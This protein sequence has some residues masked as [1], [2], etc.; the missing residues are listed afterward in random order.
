MMTQQTLAQTTTSTQGEP[1][2]GKRW[3][4]LQQERL[5]PILVVV[6]AAA[7]ASSLVAERVGAPDSLILL[8][9]IVSYVAGGWFGLQAGLHSL[10]HRELNVDLLM[11]LAAG[12]AALVNQW[13]EGAILLFLFSLSN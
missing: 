12:G 5:E 1:S 8:I 4:F 7:I 13:H 6:T 11:V 2:E 10:L 3:A 9:N